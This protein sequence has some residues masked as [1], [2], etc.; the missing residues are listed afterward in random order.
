MTNKQQWPFSIATPLP[1]NCYK[2]IFSDEG[3][4]KSDQLEFETLSNSDNETTLEEAIATSSDSIIQTSIFEAPEVT[5]IPK[6][7]Y[8]KHWPFGIRKQRAP[9]NERIE[10]VLN[11][12]HGIKDGAHITG[13]KVIPSGTKRTKK[14]FYSL[15]DDRRIHSQLLFEVTPKLKE[16]FVK[17][18][19]ISKVLNIHT[20]EPL[21]FPLNMKKDYPYDFVVV[22]DIPRTGGSYYDVLN[23]I[24]E[25]PRLLKEYSQWASKMISGVHAKL[26]AG[27]HL[28][29]D[30][31]I[32]IPKEDI[33]RELKQRFFAGFKINPT[34]RDAVELTRSMQ[35]LYE[36]LNPNFNVVSHGDCHGDNV[37]SLIGLFAQ[38]Q[39]DFSLIDWDTMMEA[40]FYHDIM[41]L[42]T[43][44][45]RHIFKQNIGYYE[46]STAME[47]AYLKTAKTL[48]MINKNSKKSL[49]RAQYPSLKSSPYDRIVEYLGININEIA[50]P[51]RVPNTVETI[52]KARY[53][54][55]HTLQIL[56][57]MQN[58]KIDPAIKAENALCSLV[59]N[60][61][62]FQDILKYQF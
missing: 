51:R 21:A 47:K 17:T 48:H 10:Q 35:E 34:H 3:Y 30:E 26:T 60:V 24:I 28:F 39:D 14:V 8:K 15:P 19:I 2:D 52:W 13:K 12:L 20:S 62:Y 57:E 58:K 5:S 53:H 33:G 1:E 36:G 22:K 11:E 41:D 37:R 46:G 18:Q 7:S 40:N 50:D 54:F 59:R 4:E 16:E 23:T 6:L 61:P 56:N 25:E 45:L 38:K 43:H 32:T 42:Y 29:E 31:G 49:F 55:F 9:E 27:R 44:Q